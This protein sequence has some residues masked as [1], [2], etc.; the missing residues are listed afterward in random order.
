MGKC[1]RRENVH[2]I[3]FYNNHLKKDP[4]RHFGWF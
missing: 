3:L 2:F 4:L 1:V